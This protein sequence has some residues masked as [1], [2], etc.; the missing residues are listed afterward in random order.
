MRKLTYLAIGIALLAGAEALAIGPPAP[1]APPAP[2]PGYGAPIS[3]EQAKAAVA[4]AEAEMKANGWNMVIAVVGPTG[5]TIYLQKADLAANGSITVAQEKARTSAL[6]RAPTK[7]FQDR[8]AG[9]DTYLLRLP[10]ALPVAGGVPI[11]VGGKVIG[12]IGTSGASSLQDHQ[13]AA[14]GAAA[15]K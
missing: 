13:V 5:E 15:V 7:A 2:P 8:L 4:A 12:A 3:L 10:G 14:A 6:F 9:G 11:I 1:A